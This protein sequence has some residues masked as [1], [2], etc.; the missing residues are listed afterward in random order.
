MGWT[1]TLE[2][3]NQQLKK[4]KTQ[5]N[6]RENLSHYALGDNTVQNIQLGM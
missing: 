3:M 2:L 6:Q 1:K 5:T 4:K